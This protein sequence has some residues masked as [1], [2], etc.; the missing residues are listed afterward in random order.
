[1]PTAEIE[2]LR[3]LLSKLDALGDSRSRQRP[4]ILQESTEQ[5]T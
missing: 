1:M 3:A 5:S 2:R 4:A